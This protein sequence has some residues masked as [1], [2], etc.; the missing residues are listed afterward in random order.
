LWQHIITFFYYLFFNSK[1]ININAFSLIRKRIFLVCWILITLR[2]LSNSLKMSLMIWII[3]F[4]FTKTNLSSL[5]LDFVKYFSILL[6]YFAKV[7]LT[8]LKFYILHAYYSII[9]LLCMTYN[10]IY[11]NYNQSLL[12]YHK[13]QV[14][15]TILIKFDPSF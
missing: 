5:L 6:R 12:L 9:K 8:I 7:L 13:Y 4:K 11:F 1:R 14:F 3:I 2:K 15:I 10:T